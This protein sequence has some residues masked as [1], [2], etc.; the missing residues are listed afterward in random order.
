[1]TT[2]T[3]RKLGSM[4]LR[5]AEQALAIQRGE[6][7]PARR[8]VWTVRE[9]TVTPPPR[10]RAAR[11]RRLRENLGLSQ[12]LFASTLNVSVGTV[13]A[14]E[15][16]VRIPDGPSRRLLEVAEH[17]PKAILRAVRGTRAHGPASTAA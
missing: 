10:Y 5:S 11:I 15:Q 2:K 7:A 3:K 1:M 13:R 16:G 8:H 14:W 17:D 4:L 12:P 6:L 9:A